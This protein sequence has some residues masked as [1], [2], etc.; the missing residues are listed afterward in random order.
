MKEIW[1]QSQIQCTLNICKLTSG[2]WFILL[3]APGTGEALRF[4]PEAN[5][6]ICLVV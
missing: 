6:H 3:V 4:T 1:R 5:V 2:C